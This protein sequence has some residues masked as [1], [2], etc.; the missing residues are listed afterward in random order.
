MN[1]DEKYLFD[2]NGY[3]V[4]REILTTEEVKQLNDGIDQHIGQLNEMDRS[5][6]GGSQALAGISHRKDMGACWRGINP[7]VNHIEI[8]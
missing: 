8:S 3:L 1:K 6:S 4:L 5:L 2:L 7:G